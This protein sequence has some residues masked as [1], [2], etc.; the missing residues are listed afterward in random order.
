M[1]A[2]NDLKDRVTDKD[3]PPKAPLCS[4]ETRGMKHADGILAAG[5]EIQKNL[6]RGIL[7]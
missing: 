7:E 3:V 5:Q 4:A 2:Y 6:Q 1:Q